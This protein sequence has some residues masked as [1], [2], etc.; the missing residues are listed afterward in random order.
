MIFVDDVHFSYPNG[1]EVLNGVNLQINDGEFVA[2]MGE[3][4]AGKTTL[5]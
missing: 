1:R 5:V 4:G 3:N 2:V